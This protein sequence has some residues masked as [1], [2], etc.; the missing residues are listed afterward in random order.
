MLESK[1]AAGL[2]ELTNHLRLMNVADEC[3]ATTT[4]SSVTPITTTSTTGFGNEFINDDER[5]PMD[6]GTN[7]PTPRLQ[8]ANAQLQ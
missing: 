1:D 4:I 8:D 7:E 2:I 6:A 3:V 5:E